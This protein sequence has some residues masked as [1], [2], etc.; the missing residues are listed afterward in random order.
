MT[1]LGNCLWCGR[2]FER[3]KGGKLQRFCA[4]RCRRHFAKAALAWVMDAVATGKLSREDLRNGRPA[5]PRC[6]TEEY[7]PPDVVG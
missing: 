1:E 2:S 3:R 5:T 6:A 4:E 7:K